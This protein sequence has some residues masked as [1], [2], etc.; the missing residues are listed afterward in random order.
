MKPINIEVQYDKKI[1]EITGVAS[2]PTMM[3]EGALFWFL[4][5]SV[6]TSHPDIPKTYPAGA[7]GMTINGKPPKP[8]SPLLDGDKVMFL[9]P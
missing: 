3:N 8:Y 9:V 5:E 6:L 1:Q 4:L 7:L 2:E